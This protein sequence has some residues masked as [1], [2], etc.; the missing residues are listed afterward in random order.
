MVAETNRRQDSRVA[1]RLECRVVWPQDSGRT[2]MYTRNISRHGMLLEWDAA[3]VDVPA[4]NDMLIVEIGLP[5]LEGFTRRCLRCQA[6]V[7]RV[8]SPCGE[9]T[10]W[11]ALRV[12][13]MDFQVAR[14]ISRMPF[15]KEPNAPWH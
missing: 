4:V 3:S 12:D 2:A 1:I 9:R 6:I 5:P 11:V 13:A 10:A 8:V 14:L 7:A 15:G